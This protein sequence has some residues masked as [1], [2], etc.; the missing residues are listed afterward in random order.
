M[1]TQVD[2]LCSILFVTLHPFFGFP[3]SPEINL[4]ERNLGFLDQRFAL[5]W[6]QRNIHAFGGDPSKVT[7]FGESAGAFSVDA[8]LTSFPRDLH[9]LSELLSCKVDRCPGNY[10]SNLTC[11]QAADAASIKAI[12]EENA[13]NFNPVADDVT[14]VSQPGLQRLSGNIA[15]IPVLGGTN[16]EEGRVFT[17]GQNN[18]TAYLQSILGRTNPELIPAIQAAYPLGS[19]PN[20]GYDAVAAIYTDFRYTCTQA[21]WANDSASVGIPTW[22]YFFNASF[23]N[24]QIYPSLGVFHSSEIVLVFGTYLQPNTTTQQYALS[25]FMQSAW[26]KFAKNPSVDQ[27]ANVLNGTWDVGL[28]GNRKDALSSGVTV[29][30]QEE[31]DYKCALFAPYYQAILQAGSPPS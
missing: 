1:D 13:L 20:A 30:P 17:V 15:N 9:R 8:L 14:L 28:L 4:T 31:V 5:D 10:G 2:I 24:S 18:V 12:I 21:L 16:A 26:A 3:S 25:Q 6:V 22:R 23:P 7:I 11:V 29:I 27:A 19:G